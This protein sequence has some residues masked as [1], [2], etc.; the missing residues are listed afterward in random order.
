MNYLGQVRRI[1]LNL[2]ARYPMI[3][4]TIYQIHEHQYEIV[5]S[6]FSGEFDRLKDEFDHSIRFVSTPVTSPL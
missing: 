4:T 1:D 2:R 3:E 6:E 5:V